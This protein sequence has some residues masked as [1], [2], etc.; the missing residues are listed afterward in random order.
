LSRTLEIGTGRGIAQEPHAGRQAKSPA[1]KDGCVNRKA[2]T[3]LKVLRTWSVFGSGERE[4]PDIGDAL[5]PK[6]R[7]K[8]P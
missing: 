4:I 3:T 8:I 7:Y 2:E 1:R 5:K 6:L